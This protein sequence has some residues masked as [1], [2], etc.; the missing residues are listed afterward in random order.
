[1]IPGLSPER[2]WVETKIVLDR[3]TRRVRGL[4]PRLVCSDDPTI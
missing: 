2:E 3:L 1:M 4:C